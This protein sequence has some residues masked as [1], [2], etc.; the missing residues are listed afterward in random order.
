MEERL[1]NALH[2]PVEDRLYA[3]RTVLITGEITQELAR[4]V[5]GQ[6]VALAADSEDDITLLIS[7]QG[8]HV[9]SG[10]TIHDVIRFITPRVRMI[11]SGWVASAAALIYIAVPHEDRFC[12]PNTR[13][14][15]HQ[16]AG[17][18]QGSGSE[19]AIEAEQIIKMRDR[20]NRVFARQTGQPLERIQQDTNRNF[21]LTAENAVEYGLV[22]QIIES[23]H[24]LK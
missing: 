2:R 17:A 23:V 3:T 13:F 10:D 21:W 22:G 24:E 7:S 6:L 11:G 5:S 18:I 14:L 4:R 20:V 9:E 15:L 8:G 1:L 12:L 16:P 19:V